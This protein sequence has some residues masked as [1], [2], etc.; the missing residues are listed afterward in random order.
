[1]S[2]HASCAEHTPPTPAVSRLDL[3]HAALWDEAARRLV[4]SQRRPSA[5]LETLIAADHLDDAVRFLAMVLPKRQSIWW[6]ALCVADGYGNEIPEGDLAAL[7]ATLQWLREPSE[8]NRRA[9]ETAG[10]EVTAK[11]PAG[12]LA[13]AAFM[14]GG[15]ISLPHLPFVAPAPEVTGNLVAGA[16]LLAAVHR[17]WP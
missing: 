16:I 12:A 5:V 9:A 8:S 4:V 2:Q 15:N 17:D 13:I 10:N 3:C 7:E 1:M 14:S 6:G 11:T